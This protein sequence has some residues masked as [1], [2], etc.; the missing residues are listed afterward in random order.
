[1]KLKGLLSQLK[2]EEKSPAD[3]QKAWE[4]L[5]KLAGSKKA[6]VRLIAAHSL[7]DLFSFVSVK[8]KAWNYLH[9]LANSEDICVRVCAARSI[10]KSIQAYIR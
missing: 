6:S 10:G 4:G 8:K 2:K 1:M 5:Y 9:T 3:K 7:G